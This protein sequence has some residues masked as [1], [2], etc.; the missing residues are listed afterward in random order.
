[1]HPI[2]NMFHVLHI[3]CQNPSN[4]NFLQLMESSI[5]KLHILLSLSYYHNSTWKYYFQKQEFT[6]S[7]PMDARL[8]NEHQLTVLSF[9]NLI[10]IHYL[11]YI[12]KTDWAST[13]WAFASEKSPN[14]WR[15]PCNDSYISV[16]NHR[17]PVLTSKLTIHKDPKTYRDEWE[18]WHST[19]YFISNPTTSFYQLKYT[20]SSI[21][22]YH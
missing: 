5:I 14:C 9:S 22:F 15:S 8:Q 7:E 16:P 11:S 12:K 21:T 17:W 4:V 18:M 1:M 19:S 20:Y 6:I 3:N 2:I 13:Y 10:F